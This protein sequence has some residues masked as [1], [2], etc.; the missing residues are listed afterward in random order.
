MSI[1]PP[2]NTLCGVTVKSILLFNQ[3]NH[4]YIYCSFSHPQH[5]LSLLV[6]NIYQKH[7]HCFFH[8]HCKI[9]SL[10]YQQQ[11]KL[12][13]STFSISSLLSL[14]RGK[15]LTQGWT[16]RTLIFLIYIYIPCELKQENKQVKEDMVNLVLF[17]KEFERILK[18]L[19]SRLIL[20]L[21]AYSI[22]LFKNETF[23]KITIYN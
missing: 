3:T 13:F 22:P 4:I 8:F 14:S 7:I 23:F 2:P 11:K 19:T 20:Y 10:N 6:S 16:K 18:F 21:L 17:A 1:L 15:Q 12:K 9:C 5:A